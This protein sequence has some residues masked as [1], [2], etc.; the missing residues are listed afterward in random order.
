MILHDLVP[1]YYA[2]VTLK[3]T[4]LVTNGSRESFHPVAS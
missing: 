2:K 4:H 3:I 1:F